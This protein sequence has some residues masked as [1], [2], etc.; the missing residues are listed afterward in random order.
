LTSTTP[1]SSISADGCT[2]ERPGYTL[3]GTSVLDPRWSEG[4]PTDRPT[5]IVAEGL[6]M[7]L[8]EQQGTPLFSRLVHQFPTGELAFDMFSRAAI[9]L[10][11]L[12]PV[13]RR[14]GP[15]LYWGLTIRTSWSGPFHACTEP[16]C[17]VDR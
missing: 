16:R 2:L 4:L 3:I 8:P 5:F 10:G 11:K 1:T 6:T 7:Y 12:K 9:R 14:T 13:V 15:T 17:D